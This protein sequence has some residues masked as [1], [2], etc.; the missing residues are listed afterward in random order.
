MKLTYDVA[1]IGGGLVGSFFAI[2]L[3]KK[4]PKLNIVIFER[5]SIQLNSIDKYSINRVNRVYAISQKNVKAL[6][7]LN[8]WPSKNVSTINIMDISGDA[9][10]NIILD[11]NLVN[12]PYLAKI[13]ESDNLHKLLFDKIKE[14]EN[15]TFIYEELKEIIAVESYVE[16]KTNNSTYN[17][18]LIVGADGVNSF[19]R[20]YFNI[21]SS[22]IKYNQKGV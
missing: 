3:A 11:Q 19:V 7:T 5:S 1:I 20:S 18:N 21:A 12:R 2:S 4:N 13:V 15:I 8:C 14:I 10:G 6:E 22:Q 17:T 9:G 16:I